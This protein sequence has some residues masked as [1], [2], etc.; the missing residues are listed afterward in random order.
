[1]QILVDADA[2]PSAIREILFRAA[3]RTHTLLV[4]VANVPLNIPRSQVI[5]GIVVPAGPDEADDKI[6]EMVQPC[7][8]VITADI[9]LADR[10]VEKGATVIDPRGVMYSAENIKERLT[11]RNLLDELRNSGIDTGG[12]SRFTQKDRKAFANQL[13]RLLAKRADHR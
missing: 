6:A 1:M 13:D 10:A 3:E 7:D 2:I 12:P 11:M 5:T 8:I 4:L 9:P